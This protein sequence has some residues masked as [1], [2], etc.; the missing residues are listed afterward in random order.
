MH[1][2]FLYL[3]S[4]L[5]CFQ[6]RIPNTSNEND[7]KSS[8]VR[9]KLCA[10]R[11]RFISYPSLYCR[12]G[13]DRLEWAETRV[14]ERFMSFK[15]GKRSSTVYI[16]LILASS[17]HSRPLGSTVNGLIILCT[18]PET[19][20]NVWEGWMFKKKSS[21]RDHEG[22]KSWKKWAH[23]YFYSP[24][25]WHERRSGEESLSRGREHSYRMVHCENCEMHL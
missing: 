17:C 15:L 6:I 18:R 21:W 22:F 11:E 5:I 2:N 8:E 14:I 7:N 1:S 23:W 16:E 20:A 24:T 13:A 9:L 10:Y 4:L 12:E 19:Y 3:I 25:S